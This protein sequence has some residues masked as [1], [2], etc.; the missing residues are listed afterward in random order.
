V[1]PE[2]ID[3]VY[4]EL[5]TLTVDLVSDPASLGPPY[6]QDLIFKIR[7]Y[8]NR[9]SLFTSEVYWELHQL[10]MD[11]AAYE[12]AYQVSSDDL[13]ATDKRVTM[14]PNLRDRVAMINHILKEDRSK[15]T[16]CSRA[17]KEL[18]LVNRVIRHRHQELESTVSSIRMQRSLIVSS[19]KT[20]SFYG[21]EGEEPRKGTKSL[22]P[23]PDDDESLL[24][25]LE[26]GPVSISPPQNE[27]DGETETE[28][29]V[30]AEEAPEIEEPQTAE[31][32]F[33][34]LFATPEPKEAEDAPTDP[35]EIAMQKFLDDLV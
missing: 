19:I 26:G 12:A 11:L 35:D 21:D 34:D 1:S 16:T 7:G 33:D 32:A 4:K 24:N 29:S 22:K 6:L 30:D 27:G 3:Q 15:I 9:V 31:E 23:M 10:E 8:L 2:R 20:G 5:A 28:E 25:W 13:L 17:I 14:L 18:K